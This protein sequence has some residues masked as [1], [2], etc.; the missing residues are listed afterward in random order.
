MYRILIALVLSC[1]T[2]LLNA[3]IVYVNGS[4]T[5][6]NNGTTWEHAFVSL[7]SGIAA[8]MPGDEIWVAAGVYKPHTVTTTPTDTQRATAF[9]LPSSV[10]VYGGF[11][12]TETE[13]SQRDWETNST[14]LSG[15]IGS[16]AMSDNSLHVVTAVNTSVST[17]L[18]GF[19]VM[20][21]YAFL[22]FNSYIYGGGIYIGNGNLTIENCTFS[23]NYSSVGGGA[24]AH[25]G[26]GSVTGVV[27]LINSTVTDNSGNTAALYLRGTQFIMTN[28]DISN[29]QGLSICNVISGEL[30]ADRCVF[31]GNLNS[32]NNG[33]LSTSS[34]GGKLLIYNSLFCGNSVDG[35]AAISV[36]NNNGTSNGRIWNC[37][38]SGNKSTGTGAFNS[39][40]SAGAGAAS[41]RNCIIW[42]NQTNAPFYYVTDVV[43]HSLVQGGYTGTGNT[44]VDPLFVN[45]GSAQLAPFNA[46]SFDYS[47]Q[48]GSPAINTGNNSYLNEFYNLDLNNNPRVSAITVDR[49]GYEKQYCSAEATITASGPT[50]F[51]AGEFVTLTASE[52]STYSWSSGASS[53]NIAVNASGTYSVTVIDQNGCFGTAEQQVT[54]YPA[55]VA[56]NGSNQICV[57]GSTVL[58]AS[59]PHGNI[60]TWSTGATTNSI[61]VTEAGVYTVSVI[62]TNS[63]PATSA[64]L[65]VT[66]N[67]VT[68]PVITQNGLVLTSST[69]SGNQWYLNGNPIAGALSQ[70]YTALQNGSYTVRVTSN[71]CSSAMSAPVVITN[72]EV[73]EYQH[74]SFTL[75]PNPAS[76]L[77]YFETKEAAVL[78]TIFTVEGKII[79]SANI[80]SGKALIEVNQWPRGVYLVNLQT[81]NHLSVQ[82]IVLE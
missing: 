34:L 8:A 42:G 60:F 1:T 82:K 61:T 24:I 75:Y 79:H 46:A 35:V 9:A 33:A 39:V 44:N 81:A 47:L 65:T 76:D 25:G 66:V 38:F 80:T 59:S 16:S 13:L 74:S 6:N 27:R 14:I 56:I 70:S 10:A 12:G 37:T 63:C 51:C 49:G 32:G 53:Q 71:A 31:S 15:N 62:T 77:L 69:P 64:P 19:T 58:T 7:Q 28:C 23:N 26:S 68:T 11:I 45:P 40:I 67:E 36:N 20:A 55:S 17:R 29:N 5:G 3:A 18:D 2:A 41:V 4:A 57:G 50:A 78:I 43:S 21:G 52:G 22:S 72:V 30:V 73:G 48:D 54:V